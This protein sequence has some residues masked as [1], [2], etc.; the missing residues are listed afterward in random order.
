MTKG[1]EGVGV[2]EAEEPAAF[3]LAVVLDGSNEAAPLGDLV[4]AHPGFGGDLGGGKEG[5]VDAGGDDDGFIAAG[6]FDAGGGRI[7]DDARAAGE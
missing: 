7:L 3:E 6:E 1:V 2:Y 4:D 5:L